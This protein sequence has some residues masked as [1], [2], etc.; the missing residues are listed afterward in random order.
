MFSKKDSKM[1]FKFNVSTQPSYGMF[2]DFGNDAVDAIIRTAKV[3]KMSWTQVDAE[4][5]SLAQRFP[6]D[7][8]EATDTSV[9]EAVYVA[10]NFG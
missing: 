5:E 8:S 7:F 3:L 4:L 6:N 2:T 10:C 9:R 1:S